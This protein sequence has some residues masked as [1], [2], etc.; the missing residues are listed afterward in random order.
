ML[1]DRIAIGRSFLRMTRNTGL[2]S[3]DPPVDGG[4]AILE[5]PVSY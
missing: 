3:V 2:L 1:Q 4:E 5:S